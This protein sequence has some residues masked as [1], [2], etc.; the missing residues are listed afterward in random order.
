MEPYWDYEDL[1]AFLF[2]LVFLNA[3]IRLS[4]RVH[5][6]HPS[7]LAHS[8][9][10]VQSLTIVLLTI[11]LYT[12]LKL[13]YHQ[14]V[15]KPLGWRIPTRFYVALSIV[16]GFAAAL[17]ITGLIH[18]RRHVMPAIPAMDFFVLGLLLGPIL[19]ESVFRGC[20]LPV[21]ARTLGNIAS[22]L[23]TGVLFAAFHAPSDIIH[24]VWFMT[25]GLAYGWLRVAS[26]TTTA[27]ALMHVVCNLTLFLAA[28][29]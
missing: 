4:V 19:E 7:E 22:V 16:S 29:V 9:L 20:L 2:V 25:T 5:L 28:K 12:I 18:L 17:L 24:W 6:L 21:L 26:R 14:P 15:M 11:A 3:A 13:R 8:S 1:G 27:P 10:V 23:A